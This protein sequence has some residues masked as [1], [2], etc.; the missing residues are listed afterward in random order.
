MLR[1]LSFLPTKAPAHPLAVSGIRHF[2]KRK[3]KFRRAKKG[4]T[5]VAAWTFAKYRRHKDPNTSYMDE[6]AEGW[7]YTASMAVERL[8][9]LYQP[10]APWHDEWA[11][12]QDELDLKR[13]KIVPL[14]WM[15]T[16]KSMDEDAARVIKPNPRIT[17]ED[18]LDDK[19]NLH[20]ILDVSA[21]LLVK[22]K[23]G[24]DFPGGKWK[25]SETIRETAEQRVR[26]QCGTD[27]DTYLLGNAPVCHT[28]DTEKKHKWFLM[29]NLLVGGNCTIDDENVLDFAWVPKTEFNQYIKDPEKLEL[30]EKVF[31]C[32]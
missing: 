25:E 31:F 14:E 6:E 13:R 5:F 4:R 16:K 8:P 30:L 18:R 9:R 29:H 27:L 3:K 26:E 17:E 28:E 32:P 11:Q 12:F 21:F 20:R 24:W 2:A 23:D 1:A 10:E 19:K 22:T 7:T 15:M